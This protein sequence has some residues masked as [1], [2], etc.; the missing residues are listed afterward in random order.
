MANITTCTRCG[1]LYEA[2]SEETANESV[3]VCPLCSDA[4][5]GCGRVLITE[6]ERRSGQCEECHGQALGEAWQER[7]PR[8]LAS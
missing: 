3:R 1:A 2:G 5:P 6:G 4:C 7:H 8:G